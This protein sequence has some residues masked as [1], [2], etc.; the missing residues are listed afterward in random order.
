MSDTVIKEV[1]LNEARE[2]LSNVESDLVVFEAGS[3]PEVLNRIF[4]YVHTLKG[5][6]SMAGYE[7]VSELMHDLETV[8][9]RLRSGSLAVDDRL[10][11]ILLECFDWVK[12]ALFDGG[13]A[14]ETG[15]AQRGLI[16]RM[17]AF[18]AEKPAEDG[19]AAQ[20][21][22]AKDY[23]YRYFRVR[24]KFRD[25]IFESGIDPLSII[26]D[27]ISLGRVVEMS[28]DD[29]L[30]ELGSLDPE[31]CYLGWDITIK[32]P[33]RLEQ[34]EEVFLFVK[35][36]NEIVLEDVT[37][38]FIDDSGGDKYLEEKRIGEI[39]VRKGILTRKELDDVL[40][41][42]ELTNRKIGDIIVEK[43][44]AAHKDIQY[45]LGEQDRIRTKI[46]TGTVRVDTRKLDSLMNLLGEIVIGQSAIARV[47]DELPE[48][49]GFMLKNALYGL[50]RTTREFQE[51]IMAIRMIPI[52]ATFEQ[53]R[54]FVRD[55]AR[56]IGKEIRLEIFGEETELDKTVI[57]KIS[58]PLKHMIRNA[59]D[60]GIE[61]PAERERKGK[62][63]EGRIRLNAYH[64]EG[65]MFIE[66]TDDGA[67]LDVG[68][69]R[70]KAVS[71]GLMRAGDELPEEKLFSYIFSPGF[72]TA[73]EAGDLS[74][75]GVGMDVV[76]TNIEALR[77]TVEIDSAE[78]VGTTFLIKLPL[79]LAIIEGMLVRSGVNIYI[80]PLLS[81]VECIQPK[82]EDVKVVEGSGEL[83]RV[84]EKYVPLVRLY[85]YFGIRADC[86]N[87]WETIVVIVET[88]KETLGIMVD[89]LVGQQQIVIKSLSGQVT[90]SRAVSGAAIL[91]DGKVALILDVH[92]LF[93]EMTRTQ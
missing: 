84:R 11:D 82:R 12:L 89:E 75:R 36:D 78:N 26:E 43:G 50:D 92:G 31:K 4:R 65:N 51:Q 24:A 32:A 79:T 72:T 8:L 93:G 70:S 29:D 88:G 55:T 63:R 10:V 2:I 60:H 77:G 9:D 85:D 39:L 25:A 47:A 66:V 64:Q 13:S 37:S 61:D 69:I 44:Y 42:Q 16:D 19:D 76:K 3:D 67:G 48:E 18:S 35:D 5:S 57:E 58:D 17:A 87:P 15:A 34:A 59:V 28:V 54:R 22:E 86:E 6:S 62:S 1:F 46:E 73:E 71:L 41:D 56:D 90:R 49:Q 27:F 53:F 21:E 91:G 80:V 45:A 33:C 74:G 14:E 52:G 38:R 81:I 30:P 83:I 23:G 7:N 40:A 20:P 68:K